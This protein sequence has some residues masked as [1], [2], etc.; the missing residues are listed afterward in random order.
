MAARSVAEQRGRAFRALKSWFASE[1]FAELQCQLPHGD[2]LRPSYVQYAG[3]RLR[4]FKG[5]QANR[6]RISLPDHVYG[7][8]GQING[9]LFEDLLRDIEENAI[10]KINSIV[11]PQ[12][13][14][15]RAV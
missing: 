11:Q 7:W 3:R 6:I 1:A 13:H 8:H 4:R 12:Q 10:T 2:C 9:P 14:C 15:G 5:P